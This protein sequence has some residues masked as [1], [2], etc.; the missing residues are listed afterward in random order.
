[1]ELVSRMRIIA[2]ICVYAMLGASCSSGGGGAQLAPPVDPPPANQRPAFDSTRA[3]SDL[4]AQVAFGARTPGSQ[5]HDDCL[6]F[7]LRRL[8]DAG[9]RVV[10]QQ[11]TSQT[12]LGGAE[13]Y[14]FTNVAGL[15]AADA[16]GDVLML[17]AHWDSRAKADEDPDPALRDQP[18]PG[19]NDGASGVSV[20][21]EI[22]RAFRDQAPDRPVLI[23]FFDAEDQGSDPSTQ[24]PEG[25]WIL[26]SR[27]MAEN[28][29]AELP[30]PDQMILLDLVGGDSEPN[31]RLGTPGISD[32]RFSLPMERGSLEH[33]PDLVDRIWTI[34][35]DLG[36]DAFER[37]TG[38]SVIDDHVPFQEAGV[39]AIDIIEFVPPEWH[40][41]D[42]TPEHCSAD[43]LEQVG[44]TLLEY[45]YSE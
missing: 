22:V 18:V 11:F 20:L 24:W 45:I 4:E 13:D 44:E 29:P 17:A 38:R 2:A 12:P 7:L 27:H 16:P 10:T 43:S 25:G 28:W 21:L 15:F 34:A 3:F 35:A 8:Q 9:A 41:V 6:Q 5:A 40:T 1:M 30:W 42:D 31:E 33:A 19:A 23:V 26:G 39:E 14:T 36:H 32:N 37:R